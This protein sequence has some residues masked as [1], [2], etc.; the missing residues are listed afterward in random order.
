MTPQLIIATIGISVTFL[1]QF[2]GIVW[3][4]AS[5]RTST[6]FQAQAINRLTSAV[7]N[8]HAAV[9]AVDRRVTVLETR[10]GST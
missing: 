10:E 6:Q 8:L 5:I 3:F 4:A 7:E 9:V 2:G 1:V